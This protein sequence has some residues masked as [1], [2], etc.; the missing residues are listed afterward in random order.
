[1]SFKRME[2]FSGSIPQG[3][4]DR[5]VQKCPL[6][7][8]TNP[9][10]AID[11]KK[12]MKLEGNLYLFQCEQCKGVLSATVPDVTGFNKSAL[13][14]MG[15]IKKMSGKKNGTI[16]MRIYDKGNSNGVEDLVG[17]EFTLE[18]INKM[19]IDKEVPEGE[20]Q[21]KYY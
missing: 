18:E 11:Q 9:H 7:G 21:P 13:T 12:Q 5:S 20:Q 16:Y 4:I 6:C 3:F 17:K 19:A 10:W 1:M 2:G 8:T 15:L 14:T